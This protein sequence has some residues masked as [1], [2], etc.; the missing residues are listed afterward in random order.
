MKQ[1]IDDLYNM[2]F[3]NLHIMINKLNFQY[4][5][6]PI[7][8]KRYVNFGEYDIQDFGRLDNKYLQEYKETQL[9]LAKDILDNG[10]Y[11]PFYGGVLEQPI[12][13]NLFFILQGKHR[14]YAL[15]RYLEENEFFDTRFLYIIY[16]HDIQ[17]FRY[18]NNNKEKVKE[19]IKMFQINETSKQIEL[20]TVKT[21]TQS[22]KIMD[23]FGGVLGDLIYNYRQEGNKFKAP[24]LL[25]D[26]QSFNIFIN[27]PFKLNI[28]EKEVYL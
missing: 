23:V 27:S 9:D 2:F 11:V 1:T 14:L 10:M 3:Y 15:K 28:N 25:T 4:E 12:N 13:P 17:Y 18:N 6:A 7:F 20:I 24:E 5:W 26:E 19:E 8:W 22:L 16:P 21:Y